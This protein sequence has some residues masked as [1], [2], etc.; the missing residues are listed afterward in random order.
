M[1][2]S[3]QYDTPVGESG[4][5]LSGGQKQRIAIA[6]ALVKNPKILLLDEGT[7]ALDNESE[8]IVQNALNKAKRGRTTLV[9]AHRLSTIR[10]SDLIVGIAGGSVEEMGSYDDLMLK[11]GVYYEL[12]KSETKFENK[13]QVESKNKKDFDSD[14]DT[15][16]ESITDE[17]ENKTNADLSKMINNSVNSKQKFQ[18]K[19]R[20]YPFFYEKSILKLQK[21]EKMWIFVGVVAQCLNGATFPVIGLV[22]S[23]IYTVF[24]LPDEDEQRNQSLKYMSTRKSPFYN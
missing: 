24:S 5:Q 22:F 11:K 17:K 3:Q 16:S 14:I 6:R 2:T 10:N 19:K 21:E 23:E 13:E 18:E 1:K 4:A 9:I 12:R 7:S 8:K 15:K 20:T